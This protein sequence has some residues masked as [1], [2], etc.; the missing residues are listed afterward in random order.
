MLNG[1]EA[2]NQNL[3]NWKVTCDN[4]RKLSQNRNLPG[5]PHQCGFVVQASQYSRTCAQYSERNSMF[6]NSVISESNKPIPPPA[7]PLLRQLKSQ[8]SQ[9]ESEWRKLTSATNDE[10]LATLNLPGVTIVGGKLTELNLWRKKMTGKIPDFSK[11]TALHTLQ[12]SANDWTGPVPDFS[13]NVNLKDL[14][15]YGCFGLR[16]HLPDF[17]KNVDL[18]ILELSSNVLSGPIPDFSK[19]VELTEMYL[20]ANEFTGTIPDFSKN[21]KLKNLLLNTN[22]LTGPVPDFSANVNLKN[23]WLSKNKLEFPGYTGAADWKAN[24]GQYPSSCTVKV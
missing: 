12:I 9:L 11:N 8:S 1:A 4:T 13:K 7:A 21:V 2:F 24:S 10:D 5:C 6:A 14:Q 18:S 20:Q 15:F 23:L 3:N 17:S 19:N 22:K 16:G